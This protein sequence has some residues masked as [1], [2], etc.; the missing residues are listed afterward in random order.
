MSTVCVVRVYLVCFLLQR[1]ERVNIAPG[2]LQIWR[3]FCLELKSVCAIRILANNDSDNGLLPVGTKPLPEPML[4]NHQRGPVA[5]TW[6][7]FYNRYSVACVR[8]LHFWHYN[9]ISPG[10]NELMCQGLVETVSWSCG[11]N[12][13]RSQRCKR[14]PFGRVS[15]RPLANLKKHPL[16]LRPSFSTNDQHPHPRQDFSPSNSGWFGWSRQDWVENGCQMKG[17][18]LASTLCSSC[19]CEFVAG[20]DCLVFRVPVHQREIGL[21]VQCGRRHPG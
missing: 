3:S 7:R 1:K 20:S 16:F 2:P 13:T 19:F 6:E 17:S 11:G 10:A 18:V 4:I 21:C 5:F 9:H 12:T 15:S 14:V 8:M